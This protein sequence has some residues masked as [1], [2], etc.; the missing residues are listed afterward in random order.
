MNTKRSKHDEITGDLSGVRGD[1]SGVRGD[2]SGVTGDLSHVTGDLSG[3]TGD[4]SGVRGDLSGVR[5]DLSGVRGDL[6]GVRGDLSRVTGNLSGVT[7]DLSGVRGEFRPT[8]ILPHVFITTFT[9]RAPPTTAPC[10]YQNTTT[11]T[12]NDI[13]YRVSFEEDIPD[14]TVCYAHLS[15]AI[16]GHAKATVERIEG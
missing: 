13:R 6:S 5:G 4:L 16:A 8:E 1:L 10:E 2:L 7:G 3:V 12:D 14:E 15:L 9:P 11:C